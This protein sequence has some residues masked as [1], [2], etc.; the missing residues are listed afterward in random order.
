MLK[1]LGDAINN[2]FSNLSERMILLI[3]LSFLVL[4]LL[5]CLGIFFRFWQLFEFLFLKDPWI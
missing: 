3:E 2:F 1:E 5:M 4:V